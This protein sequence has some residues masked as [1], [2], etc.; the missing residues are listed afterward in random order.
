MDNVIDLKTYKIFLE[1]GKIT[2]E[3][4]A[5]AQEGLHLL[6]ETNLRKLDGRQLRKKR[7]EL[8]WFRL[9]VTC[10]S[11]EGQKLIKAQCGALDRPATRE[12][13]IETITPLINQNIYFT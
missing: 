6:L 5:D 4:Y 11:P 10:L 2:E 13:I 7:D 8:I 12:E 9:M 3:L 1:T